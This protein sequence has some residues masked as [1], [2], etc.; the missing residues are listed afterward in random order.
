MDNDL[1]L[2]RLISCPTVR[3]GGGIAKVFGT[4]RVA[5]K[6]KQYR[7]DD[8]AKAFLKSLN[9]RSVPHFRKLHNLGVQ[10]QQMI[11]HETPG[12]IV[13]SNAVE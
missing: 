2:C 5:N 7:S 12:N 11:F 6:D 8:E 3:N 10:C 4:D 13:E 9:M 1:K